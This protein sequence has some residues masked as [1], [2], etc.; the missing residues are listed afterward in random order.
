MS[1]TRNSGHYFSFLIIRHL[2]KNREQG[3]CDWIKWA[4]EDAVKTLSWLQF[5]FGTCS[6]NHL[7]LT[8]SDVAP[9]LPPLQ[10]LHQETSAVC[11]TA[12]R[13]L[14]SSKGAIRNGK[15]NQFYF[16]WNYQKGGNSYRC[17]HCRG[18]GLV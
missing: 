11:N 16:I 14:F 13:V 2:L 3:D 4:Q 15:L 9:N 8:G 6:R 1:L 7:F 10:Y 12:F 17:L 5:H 18:A